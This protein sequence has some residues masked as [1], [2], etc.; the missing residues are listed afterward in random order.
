MWSRGG[1]RSSVLDRAKAQLS[2]Q[3]IS[4]NGLSKDKR[5]EVRVC[6]T[7]ALHSTSKRTRFTFLIDVYGAIS[8]NI[9]RLN[10]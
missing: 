9:L 7:T 3:R 6:Y 8:I 2:G 10:N 4:N 5:N 1:A